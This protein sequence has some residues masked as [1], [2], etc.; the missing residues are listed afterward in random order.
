MARIFCSHHS[1]LKPL[2]IHFG[3]SSRG[4]EQYICAV[5]SRV[6]EFGLGKVISLKDSYG[7]ISGREENLFFHSRNLAY[8][9]TPSLG[10]SVSFEVEFLEDG[11]IQAIN[12]RP[13]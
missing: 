12:V 2:M 1:D 6:R 10:L 11:K 8:R 3:N 9:F 13:A 7:F 4:T 5:C